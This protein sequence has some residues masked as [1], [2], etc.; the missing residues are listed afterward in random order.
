[1]FNREFTRKFI[2][3][4]VATVFICYGLGLSIVYFNNNGNLSFT[5]LSANAKN[6]INVDQQKQASINSIKEIFI[7]VSS[8]KVNIISEKR[9]DVKVSLTG[10]IV[11]SSSSFEPLLE[12]DIQGNTLNISVKSQ[13][14]IMFAS[15]SSNLK[16]DI[17]IPDS[18]AED[19]KVES[20]SGSVDIGN[21]NLND[22]SLKLSSGNL[23]IKN[24]SCN[25]FAYT[26]L[27]GSL[28]ADTINAKASN[29]K[30]SSGQVSISSLTGD[31]KANCS[32]GSI[33]ISYPQFNNNIDIH[34]SSG[35][36]ELTLPE[37]SEFALDSKA[38]SGSITCKFP[39]TITEKQKEN[40][41]RG[42]VKN[43]KNKITLSSLSGSI[44]VL[45]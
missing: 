29:L 21:M 26:C 15:F 40:L 19:L 6:S 38:S 11:S 42:T 14:S 35:G 9:D 10:N 28:I 8:S 23:K 5:N 36:I 12:T 27:S 2:L 13:F 32:S 43:D 18:Y 24:L 7:D 17:Y 25:N 33:N 1:M 37:N 45:K 3:Y 31:L 41:L 34:V 30:S 20:S 22:V 39:I 44:K 4:L 16:L